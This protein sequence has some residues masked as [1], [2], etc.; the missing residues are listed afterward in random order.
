[1]LR[2]LTSFPGRSESLVAVVNGLFGDTFEDRYSRWSTPMTVRAGDTVLPFDRHALL[3]CLSTVDVGQ[4]ICVLVHGLMSTES[5]WGFANDPSTTYGTLLAD[6]HDVTVLSV[7]YNTGRHISTNGRELAHLLNHLVSAW[8]VRVREVNLIGHSMGGLVVRSACH[9]ACRQHARSVSG[10]RSGGLDQQGASSR[11][12]RCAE[13]E[14]PR[15]SSTPPALPCGRCL[16]PP[17]DSSGSGSTNAARASR[18]SASARSSTRI[19]SSGIPALV[20]ASS[21]TGR[22]ASVEPTIS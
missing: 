12:D 4:R 7:R 10:S 20:N 16:F 19:G 21:A 5:I 3:D 17:P 6:D 9:Y 14:G 13:Q 11:T 1:M 15:L 22:T 8:P 2:V 18:T